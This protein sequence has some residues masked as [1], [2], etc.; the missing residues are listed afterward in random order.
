M[1]DRHILMLEW[2]RACR[3]FATEKAQGYPVYTVCPRPRLRRHNS[4]HYNCDWPF[5]MQQYAREKRA[6]NKAKGKGSDKQEAGCTALPD[7]PRAGPKTAQ[8][9]P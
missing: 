2:Y 6:I 9:P 8:L 7:C 3:V 4:N 5:A 1:H